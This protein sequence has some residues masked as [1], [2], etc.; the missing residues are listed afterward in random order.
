[1]HDY[2]KII[3]IILLVI[4][5]ASACGNQTEIV[6]K[7]TPGVAAKL[8]SVTDGDTIKVNIN[9]TTES[10]RFLL[11]DTPEMGKQPQPYAEEAKNFTKKLLNGDTVYLEKDVSDRD[12]YGRLLMYIYT[13]DGKSVQEE[14]LKAG[15]ARVAYVY[16]PNT[17]YV[18][19]YYALQKE[20]QK[21][22]VGIWSVENYAQEDGFYAEA[23]EN[24]QKED[25]SKSAPSSD[26]SASFAPDQNGSCKGEIK[27]NQ[28]SNDWI[29]HLPDGAYYEKTKAEECFSTEQAAQDAGYRKSAR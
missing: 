25:P 14:L 8:L 22:G 6:S 21:Q 24:E 1:M 11:I 9:G 23:I 19:Q 4:S 16:A 12:K 7:D 3:I 20:A 2:K 17:K 27:G 18:D 5:F 10:V 15:L 29:Y 26:Q 13:P 28:G